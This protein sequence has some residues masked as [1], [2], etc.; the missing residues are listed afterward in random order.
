MTTPQNPHALPAY[1]VASLPAWRDYARQWINAGKSLAE[2]L[3]T[4]HPMNQNNAT[5][6][7]L[8][9]ENAK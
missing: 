1:R 3:A 8:M 4:V 7:Y 9:E 5:S 6:A 2:F